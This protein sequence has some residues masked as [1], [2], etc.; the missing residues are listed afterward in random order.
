MDFKQLEA[1]VKVIELASFSK[2]AEAVY[3]SQPS[4]SAYVSALEKE[5]GTVL[6]NRS[7]KE[8][9]PT[10]PGKIFYE[11]A[12]EILALKQ[13]TI[14]RIKNLSGSVSGEITIAASTVPSQY[15]LP[16]IIAAFR[17]DYP[18]ISFSVEQADTSEVINRI[19]LQK[20]ELGF[21]GARIQNDKCDF[22]EFMT[23][24]I[25]FIAPNSA[26]LNREEGYTLDEL[27]DQYP[28]IARE[29]GSGTRASYENYF[30]SQ[31]IAPEKINICASFD[32][33]QS[34][35]SAVT[36]GLGISLLSE[37]AAAEAIKQKLIAKVNLQTPLPERVLY[38]VT[39]RGFLQPHLVALFLKFLQEHLAR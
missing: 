20:A 22:K 5:L 24:K 21:V 30:K 8:L 12:L 9:S 33:T 38:Y 14:E 11:N 17:A 32:N 19:A 36:H 28:F 13:N 35:I 31:G 23:E 1:Y 27:L 15:M 37:Y 10:A 6:I 16:G 3:I 26:N 18:G 2:A 25:I 4:V 34:I 29:K 39:K 7:T